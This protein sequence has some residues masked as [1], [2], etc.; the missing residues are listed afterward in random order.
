MTK[1]LDP[2]EALF[3][4]GLGMVSAIGHDVV[5]SC[6]SARAGITRMSGLNSF[7][8]KDPETGELQPLTVSV[9]SGISDGYTGLGRLVRLGLAGLKDLLGSVD[10]KDWS[11]TGLFI[12]LRSGFH[13]LEAE[14]MVKSDPE[15]A[16]EPPDE[17][18]VADSV[19]QF[20]KKRY[21]S[22]LIPAI[23]QLAGMSIDSANQLVFFGD[24]AG[25]IVL[26]R[27]AEKR[28]REK[29]LDR[30][31]VGG[32]DCEIDQESLEAFDY[33]GIL[34]TPSKAAGF[35]P[36]EMAAFVML[37]PANNG[38]D[39]NRGG[40]IAIEAISESEESYGRFSDEPLVGRA[41]STAISRTLN[42]LEKKQRRIG[43]IIGD[44]NGDPYRAN[45]WGHAIVRL[46][47]DYPWLEVPEWYPAASFGDVGAASGCAAV[48]MA[49]R[50]LE[51]GYAG[52]DDILVW[53]WNDDGTR[54]AFSLGVIRAPQFQ[55][56]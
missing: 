10:I 1:K 4:T 17:E 29:E 20:R 43:L 26:L 33:L 52:T 45:D 19:V 25:L 2:E 49:V 12:N 48:C 42:V 6:A 23:T 51:R 18:N 13:F 41:L 28:L 37:E 31:I 47:A 50:A 7:Q 38:R 55:G 27:E 54:G 16:E 5:T 34:H 15:K 11:R 56:S 8:L 32:I 3:V 9:V 40:S 30:V 22:R 35:I 36:G 21:G 44:L 24:H 14:K 39:V 53:L 46:R